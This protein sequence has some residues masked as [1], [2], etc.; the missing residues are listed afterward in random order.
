ML[1]KGIFI[2]AIAVASA[3]PASACPM[4]KDSIPDSD[5]ATASGVPGGMNAS[6][7][8]M[9]GTMVA[10]LGGVTVQ[11]VRASRRGF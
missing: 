11:I 10:V 7:F 1:R 4:C 5:A 3:I 2:F 6:V 9:L 8:T